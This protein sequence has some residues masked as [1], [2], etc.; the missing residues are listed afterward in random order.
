MTEYIGDP[1]RPDGFKDMYVIEDV[2]LPL[3]GEVLKVYPFEGSLEEPNAFVSWDIIAHSFE[4][5]VE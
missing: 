2:N 5:Q 4:L 3:T 1:M